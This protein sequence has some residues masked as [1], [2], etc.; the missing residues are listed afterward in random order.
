MSGAE[1]AGGSDAG[2]E[3]WMPECDGE[4]S[5]STHKAARDPSG[6]IVQLCPGCL[7]EGWSTVVEVID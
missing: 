2:V 6:E 7:D 1:L 4:H 3:C 5:Q